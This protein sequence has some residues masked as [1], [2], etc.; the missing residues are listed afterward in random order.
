MEDK[1]SNDNK[2]RLSIES[3]AE[4]ETESMDITYYIIIG[5]ISL[6]VFVLLYF[7]LFSS[8]G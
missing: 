4:D 2:E 1:L 8:E 5:V 6:L 7:F 3:F